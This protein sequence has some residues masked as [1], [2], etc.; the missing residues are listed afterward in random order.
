MVSLNAAVIPEHERNVKE[1]MFLRTVV[2]YFLMTLW[3]PLFQ[4]LFFFFFLDKLSFS[5]RLPSGSCFK[6]ENMSLAC[7][8][9]LMLLLILCFLGKLRR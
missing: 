8:C 3:F 2:V 6:H 4:E 5:Y 1:E 9:A 7:F